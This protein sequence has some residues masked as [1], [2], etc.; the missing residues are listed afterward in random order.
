MQHFTL[1]K[2][3]AKKENS[4]KQPGSGTLT[5]G[6]QGIF[7]EPCSILNPVLK[8]E[9][10]ALDA[11]P[12][13]YNYARYI[14]GDKYYFIEDWVWADG[15]WEVHMKED[16]LATFKTAI[17]SQQEYILRTD[18]TTN[19]N[20]DILDA[21]YPSTTDIVSST[22]EV[23]SPF[24]PASI[25][26]GCFIVGILS[27]DD[28]DA[29]GAVTYYAMTSSQFG[30]LKDTLFSDDNMRIMGI[31]NSSGQQ[32]VTDLSQEVLK[33]LYNPYQ[34][35]ASCIWLPIAISDLP[36][37]TLVPVI[38]LGWWGYSLSAYRLGYPMINILETSITFA[39]H[40]Q[41]S[42]RGNYLNYAPYT[43]RIL[44]GRYGTIPINTALFKSG[45]S[46]Q[47]RYNVDLVT[48]SCRAILERVRTLAIDFITE[49]EFML[50]V[51][52]QIAQVGTDYL[53]TLATAVS[54]G[55]TAGQQALSLNV[56]GAI[57]TLATGIYNTIQTQMPQLETSGANGS[58]LS[59]NITT[60]LLTEFYK[61]VDEDIAHRGRPLCELRTI[62]TL[63]GFILCADGDM[64]IS[65][66]DNER[67]EIVKFL[68]TGF[69]WE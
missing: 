55:A 5:L 50:G 34:Y 31:I 46:I 25:T 58:F 66:Y 26:S 21:T 39:D 8:I 48:G 28:T 43:R 22:Q 38:K 42:Q 60:K 9:R 13:D 40:P 65:C 68:T 10:L 45:D 56:G 53:G 4:T 61:I 17:G 64:D 7:K 54:T 19:F 52:I 24:A 57:S 6:V 59:A 27:G 14:E 33:T 16:V 69:F 2:G 20:G 32:I 12:Y 44:N 41:A 3:F 23:A 37:A 67:K 63:S 1:Y 62:N 36:N 51:P 11:V 30:T 18:S 15:L 35:I 49:K 29:I 47:I